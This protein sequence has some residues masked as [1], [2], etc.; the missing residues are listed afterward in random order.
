MKRLFVRRKFKVK[1]LNSG[2]NIICSETQQY[3]KFSALHSSVDMKFTWYLRQEGWFR[4]VPSSKQK[5]V[6][7]ED[8]S[9]PPLQNREQV[10]PATIRLLSHL[11]DPLGSVGLGQTSSTAKQSTKT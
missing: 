7:M 9:K 8:G 11:K 3:T 10:V 2:G 6:S 5:V 4:N 1:L